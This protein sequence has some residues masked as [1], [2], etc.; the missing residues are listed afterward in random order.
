MAEEI[1][2]KLLVEPRLIARLR[3]HPLLK[4][5]RRASPRKLYSVYYDTPRLELWQAGVALRLRQDGSRWIQTIKRSG[6]VA[7]GL[8]RREEAEAE[9]AAPLPDFTVIPAGEL[10]ALFASPRLRSRLRPLIVT[11]F[12]RETFRLKLAGAGAIE[13]SLDH[14]SIKSG[15]GVEP[16]CEL[17]LEIKAG[18]P[19]RAYE[20][21]L[22]LLAAVPLQVE[23][24]SKAARGFALHRGVALSPRK[25]EPSP[26][27]ARMS[28]NDAFKLLV[29]S[30][31]RQFVANQR[32]MLD[33]DDPEYLHQMRVALRRLRSVF[34]TFAPL[35][36]L[37]ALTEPVAET[38]WLA[39]TLGG[40]RD[41]DVFAAD[42]VPPV[43][44]RY[45]AH[46]GMAALL[47]AASRLR[48]TAHRAA[49]RAVA[50][51]R[52][53]GLLL[54]LGG[55]LSAETWLTLVDGAPASVDERSGAAAGS[56][57]MA[58]VP[59]GMQKAD[60]GAPT[61]GAT[62]SAS[63]PPS[64]ASTVAH[65]VA[66]PAGAG[67][68][69]LARPV[70][71]FSR[72]VLASAHRRVLKRG[73][74]FSR[75]QP[76]QLHRLR[77][78]VKKLRY[79]TEFFAPLYDEGHARKYRAALT[80]LQEGL[81]AYNDAVTVSRLAALASRDLRDASAHEAH[82]ILLGW[83]AGMQDACMRPLRRVWQDF[84]AAR[85]FWD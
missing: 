36:S 50:S 51:T 34:S 16:I 4:R 39:A 10:A 76:S 18:P 31:L 32:G 41:W 69:E 7:T 67:S 75:L 6:S 12:T 64:L 37:A 48:S 70:T 19:W 45:G 53:Q 58:S 27:T 15:D 29:Q 66:P 79:A 17:E 40:A 59:P 55:W 62:G 30:C 71:G 1:E 28:S 72:T 83:S 20:L 54:A 2:I 57:G 11:E 78:A 26:L 9:I 60:G 74:H 49:R 61:E 77:I 21:A 33:T 38:R 63:P 46:A 42:T 25:A 80:R 8:H 13:A 81:G 56:A 82:G 52:G 65:S 23:D 43:A 3:G 73:R 35:L 24:R 85:P 84:R 5:A 14:G 22:Q 47:P 44:T 68:R